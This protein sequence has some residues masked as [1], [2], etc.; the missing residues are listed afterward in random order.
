MNDRACEWGLFANRALVLQ[1]A[2]LDE[3]L[4]RPLAAG[5]RVLIGC[6]RSGRAEAAAAADIRTVECHSDHLALGANQ[7]LIALAARFAGARA[8]AQREERH[9]SECQRENRGDPGSCV[10]IF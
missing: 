5:T 10:S 8:P 2:F 6:Y 1:L 3:R 9:A 4:D 7:S